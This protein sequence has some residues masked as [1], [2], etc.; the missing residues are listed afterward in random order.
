[1]TSPFRAVVVAL[2]IAS[3]CTTALEPSTP[4]GEAEAALSATLPPA[5]AVTWDVTDLQQ[6]GY[7]EPFIPA[8]RTTNDG[9]VGINL[10]LLVTGAQPGVAFFLVD[11]EKL[12]GGSRFSQT[13]AGPQ[14]LS[15]TVPVDGG[16]PPTMFAGKPSSGTLG[17][18]RHGTICD[19]TSQFPAD[20]EQTNPYPCGTGNASDCYDVHVLAYYDY[21]YS[22]GTQGIQ[23]WGTPITVKVDSPKTPSAKIASIVRTGS[24]T[25]GTT[26]GFNSLLEMMIVDGHLMTARLNGSTL[27]WTDTVGGQHQGLYNI[28]YSPGDT[29]RPKCDVTQWQNFYPITHAPYDPQVSSTYGFAQYYFRDTEGNKIA[30]GVELLG[31]Y[32]WVDRK[33]RSIFFTAVASTLNYATSSSAPAATRYSAA[34]LSSVSSADCASTTPTT[35]SSISNIEEPSNTRGISMMGLWTHG[36]MV[37]LDNTLNNTDYGL[38]VM[39]PYQRWLGLYS[40]L[41]LTAGGTG[42]VQAGSGRDTT[43]QTGI[44]VWLA[45]TTF[46][47]STEQMFNMYDWMK[48]MTPRDVV[49]LVNTGR[50]TAEVAFDDYIDPNALIVSEMTASLTQAPG[51]NPGTMAYH[52]GFHSTGDGLGTG[53]LDSVRLQNAA[54]TLDWLVPP[55]GVASTGT[56]IEPVALGGITGKGLFLGPTSSVAYQVPT[57]ATNGDS[58]VHASPWFVSVFVDCRFNDNAARQLLTF[59]DDTQILLQGRTGLIYRHQD[60]TTTSVPLPFALPDKGWAHL[61]FNVYA[62]G[63]EVDASLDG[64]A[65]NQWKGS[66]PLFQPVAGMLYLGAS[67]VSKEAGVT[68]WVDVLKV[69]AE[70][71][72]LETVCNHAHGSLI[73]F[74]DDSVGQWSYVAGLYPPWSQQNV[75]DAVLAAGQP[76]STL[77]ACY[78]DYTTRL[79]IAVGK[80]PG[81]GVS[82][83]AGLHFPAGLHAGKPRPIE[84]GNAFCVGCHQGTQAMGLTPAALVQGTLLSDGGTLLME[85]DPRRQPMQPPRLVFGNLPQNTFGP[86]APSMNELAPEGGILMDP[87]VF[88]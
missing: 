81:H 2:F 80:A 73:G 41:A 31:N 24:P 54:T 59:P 48:P 19:P 63:L 30:D 86:N 35:G 27:K 4:A 13:A 1:M 34:C 79:G 40:P 47:D 7:Q 10:K 70:Q 39:D 8:L 56:R 28:V 36:K 68:A 57:Q 61:A 49:W 12:D 17:I 20:G 23:L 14:I 72:D 11:P 46:L 9:R 26:Q 78:S 75:N 18:F 25:L 69:L 88:P 67:P 5:P 85:N 3:G 22:D 29:S 21:T 15:S 58:R 65:F 87:F 74:S 77:Y 82:V 84:S 83:R 50:A 53:F 66:A 51:S 42:W 37:L 43:E 44:P 55:Y 16:L 60:G 76:P 45:N 38:R 62:G 32:P 52:D 33:G 6:D 71:P 64:F